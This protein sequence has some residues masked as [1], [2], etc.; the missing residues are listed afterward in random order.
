MLKID[1]RRGGNDNTIAIV[2]LSG[3]IT[4][5]EGSIAF[6]DK[7]R[8]LLDS[9]ERKILL[10]LADVPYIDAPGIDE[11]VDAHTTVRN[12]AG[13]IVIVCLCRKIRDLLLITKLYTCFEIWDTEEEGLRQINA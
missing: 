9:G 8:Q 11:M 12:R 5:G 4:L 10:N 2:D 13:R 1:V 6:R 7:V 3:R